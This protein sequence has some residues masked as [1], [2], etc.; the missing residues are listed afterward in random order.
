MRRGVITALAVLAAL[1]GGS[2][3]AS[4]GHFQLHRLQHGLSVSC[5]SAT[6]CTAV[7]GDKRGPFAEHWNGVAWH[8]E[9][10]PG[11]SRD[12]LSGL[13]AVSCPSTE[14]C[15]ALG[16]TS[17]GSGRQQFLDARTEEGWIAQRPP[18]QQAL[19]RS[20]ACVTDQDC[21]AVGERVVDSLTGV[22][23]AEH[24]NGRRWRPVHVPHNHVGRVKG[25]GPGGADILVPYALASVSCGSSRMCVGVEAEG[26]GPFVEQSLM[27]WNGHHWTARHLRLPRVRH[28]VEELRSVS[29]ASSRFCLAVGGGR[30]VLAYR[31][32]GHSWKRVRAVGLRSNRRNVFGPYLDDIA[33]VTPRDCTATGGRS[34]AS[35]NQPRLVERWDGRR[36]RILKPKAQ[37][38]LATC[39]RSGH[40][41][42]T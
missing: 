28:G 9:L 41:V 19:A 17:F 2:A 35:A 20:I 1:P 34:S 8:R 23:F 30:F 31:W 4:A 18:S 16:V 39:D 40:C 26:A 10:A 7:A 24:W 38:S 11:P 25:K 36:L 42:V 27:R 33:C 3:A 13:S 32:N 15:L 22:N 37:G 6:D 5:S 29:C 12:I 14:L 21:W